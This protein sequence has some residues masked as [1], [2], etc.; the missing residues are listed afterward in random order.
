MTADAACTQ[1][2]VNPSFFLAVLGRELVCRL[3]FNVVTM[4]GN[5]AEAEAYQR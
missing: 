3:R 4:Q 5:S 1:R 2:S